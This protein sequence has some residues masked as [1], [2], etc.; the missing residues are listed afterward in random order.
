[1]LAN[2]TARQHIVLEHVI[3]ANFKIIKKQDKDQA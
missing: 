3:Q 1:M 2:D